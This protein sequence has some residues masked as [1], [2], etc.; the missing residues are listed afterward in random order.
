MTYSSVQRIAK[1]HKYHAYLANPVQQH[2]ANDYERRLNF[3]ANFIVKLEEDPQILTNI[4]WTDEAK[5]HIMD[6]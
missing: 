4:L 5:F 2:Q 1:K 3:I 6:K